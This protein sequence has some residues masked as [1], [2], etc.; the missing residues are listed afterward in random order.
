MNAV[1]MNFTWNLLFNIVN[2]TGYA[3]ASG[4]VFDH[5]CYDNY[6]IVHTNVKNQGWHDL[7]VLPEP[8]TFTNDSNPIYSVLV[9][10]ISPPKNATVTPPVVPPVV[11]VISPFLLPGIIGIV[12][13]AV[14]IAGI[15][16]SPTGKKGKRKGGKR[17]RK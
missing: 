16:A 12:I 13:I 7:D 3:N 9:F 15:I 1:N 14:A 2:V 6:F 10:G 11:P 17:R 5:N 4:L 8:N